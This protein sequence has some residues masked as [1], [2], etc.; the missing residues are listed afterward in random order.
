VNDEMKIFGRK[1]SWPNFEVLSLYSPEWT[2]KYYENL[3][4]DSRSPGRDL[5]RKFLEY[6]AGILTTRLR[7]SAKLLV[8]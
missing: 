6:K 5:N 4:Q 7:R 1:R 8:V 3:S 2:D